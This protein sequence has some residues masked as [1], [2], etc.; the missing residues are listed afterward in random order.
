MLRL[1]DEA[2]ELH[3]QIGRNALIGAEKVEF[4]HCEWESQHVVRSDSEQAMHSEMSDVSQR[5]FEIV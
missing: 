3:P 2:A 4:V 5:L 1:L